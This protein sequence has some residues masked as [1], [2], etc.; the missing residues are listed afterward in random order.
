MAI[1]STD[2]LNASV[3]K[4]IDVIDNLDMGIDSVAHDVLAPFYNKFP[5]NIANGI[6]AQNSQPQIIILSSRKS[7]V[8][9]SYHMKKRLF[10]GNG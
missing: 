5:V 10:N 1:A 6:A 8:K 3:T 2:E 4:T 9:T 7:L